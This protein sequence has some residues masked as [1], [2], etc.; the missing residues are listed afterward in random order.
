MANKSMI[1]N[2]TYT[3]PSPMKEYEGNKEPKL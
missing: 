3:T 1:T 2:Q